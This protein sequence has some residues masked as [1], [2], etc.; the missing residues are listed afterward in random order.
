MVD[1]QRFSDKHLDPRKTEHKLSDAEINEMRYAG[2]A[3]L[4]LQCDGLDVRGQYFLFVLVFS[5]RTFGIRLRR[6][7]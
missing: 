2:T 5:L 7:R 4:W 3:K 6:K 1:I